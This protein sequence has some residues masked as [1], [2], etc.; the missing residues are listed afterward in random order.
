LTNRLVDGLV[1]TPVDPASLAAFRILFGLVMTTAVVRFMALGWVDEFYVRP[2]FHFTWDLLPWIRPLPGPLM[3]LLFAALA[4]SALGVAL[5]FQYRA[6]AAL[7]FLGFTYVEAIDKTTYLNH[8][9]LVSLLS[10]LLIVLPAHRAWSV[11][12]WRR[13]ALATRTIPSS[14][15]TLL[16]FQVAAVYVFAGLAKLNADWIVEAQP[17]R[18]WLAARSDLPIIGPMLAQLWVAYAFSWCGAAYDLTIVFSLIWQRT[19]A[20]AYVTVILFH[21]MTAVLFP[22]G[23]F[24]WIMIAVTSI[25]F[26][27]DW[28]RRLLP[29]GGDRRPTEPATLYAP[30]R[31]VIAWLALYA[32]IQIAIPLRAYWP[33]T[34]PEW[35]GRGFNFAW[36]VMLI[37]KA[38]SAEFFADQPSTGRHWQ[39]RA[40][41][42]V[43]GRQEQMMAQDPYMVRTL[44]RHIARDFE[45]RG[46]PGVEVR[47]DAFASLNGRP[48]QRLI[49][50][51]VDLA[52][53]LPA[54]W[55]LPRGRACPANVYGCIVH[56]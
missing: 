29:G 41:D 21:A 5:G 24:P 16:R 1:R 22:I 31:G 30:P 25:F 38:G 3:H 13:P 49:D 52:G 36:R 10:G 40:R 20:M 17:L 27:P 4:I 18:I 55:I 47:V 39:V 26:P 34:D 2:A 42:Y 15:L 48:A 14:V 32:A 54:D 23:M 9:Y 11:D 46:V 43:T 8:Y 51:T 53:P 45:A 33:G 12:A 37:E 44:A 35:T 7:F 19:R 56:N 6:C 50:P 28:P